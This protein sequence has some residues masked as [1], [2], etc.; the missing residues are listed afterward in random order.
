M[1]GNLG[2]VALGAMLYLMNTL[3]IGLLIATISQTQHQAFLSGFLFI[4]PAVLLSGVA[5]PI[6]S[7]PEV[8]QYV[9]YVN[10]LRY[11]A[12]VNRA[13]LLKGATFWEMR[14]QL[15][16]LAALGL[17]IFGFAVSRFRKTLV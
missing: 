5:T 6:A 4:M 9:T 13:V 3:G 12:E 15:A 14:T 10:P 16:S 7:M 17:A 11:F 1:Q 2:L 8:L